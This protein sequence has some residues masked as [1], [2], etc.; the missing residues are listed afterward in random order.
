MQITLESER[1]FLK[2]LSLNELLNIKNK[3]LGALE[4]AVDI[5][6]LDLVDAAV[7]KKIEKMKKVYE[8]VHEWYTYWLIIDK[9]SHRGIGFIGFKG[10]PDGRGYSEVGYSIS[11]RYRKRG[12]MTEALQ[13][14]AEWAQAFR[15]CKGI[16]AKVLKTNTGSIRVLEHCNFKR[17]SSDETDHHYALKFSRSE[18]SLKN[19]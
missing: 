6:A 8:E 11:P 13:T 5:E 7:P 3:E 18:F 12:L 17:V 2:P 10:S 19:A 9:N 4:T 16:T 15:N 1:L 14:L